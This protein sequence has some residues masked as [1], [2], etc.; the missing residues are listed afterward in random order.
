MVRIRLTRG[1]SK[2]SPFYRII[3]VDQRVK[4]DGKYLE[5]LGTYNPFSKEVTLKRESAERWLSIGASTS[6]TVTRLLIKEGFD[7]PPNYLPGRGK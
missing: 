7:L 6:D 1:G 2:K 3:A 4:R 5:N